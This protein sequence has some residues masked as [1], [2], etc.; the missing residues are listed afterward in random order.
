[1]QDYAL[2]RVL[3]EW[4]LNPADKERVRYKSTFSQVQEYLDWATCSRTPSCMT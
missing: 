2:K 3:V 4:C 1:M